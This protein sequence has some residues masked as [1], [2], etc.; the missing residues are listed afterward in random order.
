MR[1]SNNTPVE[2]FF[3]IT[4]PGLGDCGTIAPGGTSDW[5]AYDNQENVKVTFDA[6][7]FSTPPQITPFKITIPKPHAGMTVTIGI[8]KQ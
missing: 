8:S 5:P 6:M 7:P 3:G 2:V 4:S 1:L